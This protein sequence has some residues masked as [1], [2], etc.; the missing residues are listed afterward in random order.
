MLLAV[1][2][3]TKYAG[4]ALYSA[5]TPE[6][7]RVIASRCW[8]S[9]VNHT[10]ELMPAVSQILESQKVVL[11]D[12]TGIALALGPG[13][14]SALRV[15]MSAVKGLAFISGI[16]VVG[17][18]TLD[19]EAHPYSSASVPVCSILDAGRNEVASAR[20]GRN[21]QRL[22]NDT[23]S[24]VPELLEEFAEN[25]PPLTGTQ[26]GSQQPGNSRTLFCGEGVINWGD[27]IRERMNSR[28]MVIE[29]SPATRLSSLCHLGW[30]KL[31]EGEVSDLVS[32]QPL[33]LRMPSIGGP[34][35]RDRVP[36][37]S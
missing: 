35:R 30:H 6:T 3:S 11:T 13:G 22:R 36:Q 32:L 7:G 20:F 8:Y 31:A 24:T 5:P 14:F 26:T 27:L 34:K 15:G 4:V 2:T 21:G 9:S 10:S 29:P 16:P 25:S 18:G 12:V 1:D 17:I 28:A 37:S 19:L 23:V 33:Y